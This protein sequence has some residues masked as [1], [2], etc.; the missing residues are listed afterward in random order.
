MAMASTLEPLVP[1][2]DGAV[3]FSHSPLCVDESADGE[4]LTEVGRQLAG[5]VY[6]L[7]VAAHRAADDASS[8]LPPS[9]SLSHTGYE[10][11]GRL[12][13]CVLFARALMEPLPCHISAINA[14]QRIHTEAEAA[15]KTLTAEA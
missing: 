1:L 11:A 6:P 8:Y 9:E 14:L 4:P 5:V 2:T 15:Y 3:H 12:A 7:V 10:I 13:L